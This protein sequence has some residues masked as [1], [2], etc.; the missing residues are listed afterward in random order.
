MPMRDRDFAIVDVET[1]G[2]SAESHRII[3][4]AVLR[5]T[6]G[7]LRESYSTLVNPERLIAPFIENLTGIRN[8]ELVDAPTFDEV[9]REVLSKLDGATFVAHNAHFDYGFVQKEFERQS[10]RYAAPCLCTMRLSK[11]LY[12]EHRHHGLDSIIERFNITCSERH[13]ALG[14]ARVLWDFLRILEQTHNADQLKEALSRVVSSPSHPPLISEATIRSLP[15]SA[16][17]YIFYDGEGH[18]LYVGRSINVRHRVLSHFAGGGNTTKAQE[19]FRMITDVEVIPTANDLGALLIESHMIKKLH[20][21]LN[22]RSRNRRNIVVAKR[23]TTEKGYGT[24]TLGTLDRLSFK[25]IPAIGGVFRSYRQG[26][27]FLWDLAE[28]YHLC[29]K[30]LGLEKGA[31]PCSWTQS[32][33]CRGAC[34]GGEPP[35]SYNLRF[36]QAFLERPVRTWPFK[37]P[38]LLREQ[39]NPTSDGEVFIIDNWCLV[40]AFRYNEFGKRNLIQGDLLFDYD[41]YKIIEDYLLRSKRR[42]VLKEL[43]TEEVE[44]ILSA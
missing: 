33:R 2:G 34:A 22:R 30:L 7:E 37:G 41:G 40:A 27:T 13:R 11:L 17:V 36:D 3:E 15:S 20:P 16:G 8:R 28:R 25:E 12:P 18:P 24:M 44:E 14:D 39:G 43:L 42:F 10:V 23:S 19:I 32:D 35:E 31:G 21:L 5:V 26:K 38:I 1:T 4:I 9:Y 6:D 29:P